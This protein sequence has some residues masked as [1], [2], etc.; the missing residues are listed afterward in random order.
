MTSRSRCSYP[1]CSPHR[2]TRT[3]VWY[4]YLLRSDDELVERNRADNVVDYVELVSESE[5]HAVVVVPWVPERRTGGSLLAWMTSVSIGTGSSARLICARRSGSRQVP[6]CLDAG[7]PPRPKRV[8]VPVG[9]SMETPSA[10]ARTGRAFG[11]GSI[12]VS[13]GVQATGVRSEPFSGVAPLK[14]IR[15]ARPVVVHGMRLGRCVTMA[16]PSRGCTRLWSSRQ[17]Q[18]ALDE[19]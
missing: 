15:P 19:Q 7:F 5:D 2:L 16:E 1:S 18:S 3:R 12:V 6:R 17:W 10:L 4:Q 14:V 9:S 13:I 8:D 11:R